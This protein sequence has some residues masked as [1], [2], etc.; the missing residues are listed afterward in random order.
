MQCQYFVNEQAHVTQF[1]LFIWCKVLQFNSRHV[2]S[3]KQ[4]RLW[5]DKWIC[6]QEFCRCRFPHRILSVLMQE[7]FPSCASWLLWSGLFLSAFSC[8]AEFLFFT[9]PSSKGFKLLSNSLTVPRVTQNE[10]VVFLVKF[11][12]SEPSVRAHQICFRPTQG[13]GKLPTFIHS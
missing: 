5:P 3:K 11:F 7:F 6:L 1:H 8:V 13:S 10:W 2:S 9:T 4:Q 12:S